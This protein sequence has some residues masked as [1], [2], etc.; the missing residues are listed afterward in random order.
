M[1]TA[2]VLLIA[3]LMAVVIADVSSA[4]PTSRKL[5]AYVVTSNLRP[6]DTYDVVEVSGRT[7]VRAVDS[8]LIE[9]EKGGSG[10]VFG[11]IVKNV[12]TAIKGAFIGAGEI[13]EAAAKE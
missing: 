6:F 5:H 13:G 1:K 12:A 10:T 7:F 9:D 3:A 2:G 4:L 8:P 11:G